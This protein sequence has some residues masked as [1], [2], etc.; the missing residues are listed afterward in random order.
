MKIGLYILLALVSTVCHGHEVR[1]ALLQL[2]EIERGVYEVLWKQPVM[3]D[4]R[5][6]LAPE[7][8]DDC[9]IVSE[10]T[11]EHTGTALL[12]RWRVACTLDTGTIHIR[13]LTRTL[14]DV[15]VQIDRL[16]ESRTIELLRA[17]RPTLDLENTTSPL[18]SGFLLLGMEHLLYGVDHILFIIGLVLFVRSPWLLV[19]TVTAFTVAHSITLALSV[20]E[21]VK[22]PQQPVEAVIALS[23]LFLARELVIP[24]AKRSRLTLAKPWLMA[25]AF[26]L[27]HGFGFAGALVDIGLPKE[28]LALSLLLFNV[29]IEAGQLLVISVMLT[30]GV[31]GRY[32]LSAYQKVL[33]DGFGWIMG[34]AAAFWTIDRV[35]IAL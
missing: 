14:T 9:G 29:G 25:F 2:T 24:K 18:A 8:P 3:G 31:I 19:K 17:G 32:L 35:L 15:M 5:L 22:L 33:R 30:L 11:P 34:A 27:L 16:D 20:L 1:P 13:G 7:L 10:A 28:Q 23:I 12:Q 26:G 21:L 4:R 6:A